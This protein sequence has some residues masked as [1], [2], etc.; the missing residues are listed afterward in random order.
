YPLPHRNSVQALAPLVS[1]PSTR[2][3]NT[4][5]RRSELE[6]PVPRLG[7]G[8]GGERSSCCGIES[9]MVVDSDQHS[10]LTEQQ[11]WFEMDS[12][13]LDRLPATGMSPYLSCQPST[14]N[15]SHMHAFDTILDDR[16][17]EDSEVDDDAGT[18]GFF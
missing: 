7:G 12:L 2:S 10:T 13:L 18:G 1:F 8:G 11:T 14:N 4:I 3:A 16:K 15:P 5:N 6:T 9:L 17:P